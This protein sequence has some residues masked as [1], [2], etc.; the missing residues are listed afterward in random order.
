MWRR[1]SLLVLW[2]AVSGLDALEADRSADPTLDKMLLTEAAGQGKAGEDASSAAK[3]EDGLRGGEHQSP[4]RGASV[5][6]RATAEPLEDELDNQENIISQVINAAF[7][8]KSFNYKLHNSKG[9]KY[10]RKVFS[11]N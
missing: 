3:L 11:I 7:T 2:C 6:Q 10:E 1:F 8:V 4:E 9:A 5:Q